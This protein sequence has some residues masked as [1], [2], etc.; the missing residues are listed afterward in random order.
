MSTI[1][2]APP[3]FPWK[4]LNPDRRKHLE[5]VRFSAVWLETPIRP[6]SHCKTGILV[7]TRI[8]CLCPFHESN[9]FVSI[10]SFVS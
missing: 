8:S 7:A 1:S 2:N 3:T 6:S 9:F 4:S 10:P 5:F